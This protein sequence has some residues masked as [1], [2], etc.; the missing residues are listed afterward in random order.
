MV[1]SE[2]EV[3]AIFAAFQARVDC[4]LGLFFVRSRFCVALLFFSLL[5]LESHGA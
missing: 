4:A 2:M 5:T 1:L 3:E